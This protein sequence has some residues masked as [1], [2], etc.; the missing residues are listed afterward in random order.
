MSSNIK[1]T[2]QTHTSFSHN[3][4]IEKLTEMPAQYNFVLTED[5]ESYSLF[6]IISPQSTFERLRYFVEENNGA[7]ITFQYGTF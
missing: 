2:L 3:M 6:E 1:Y 5:E 7:A 4:L